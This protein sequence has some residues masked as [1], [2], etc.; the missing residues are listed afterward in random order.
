MESLYLDPTAFNYSHVD[1]FWYKQQPPIELHQLIAQYDTIIAWHEKDCYGKHNQH[2]PYQRAANAA[3]THVPPILSGC[4]PS[5]DDF[6]T[7]RMD[8]PKYPYIAQNGNG[9][10]LSCHLHELLVPA[11]WAAAQQH[12]K[13]LAECV[14]LK[15]IVTL[16]AKYITFLWRSTAASQGVLTAPGKSNKAYN[17]AYS[18]CIGNEVLSGTICSQSTD[19]STNKGL[20]HLSCAEPAVP[21]LASVDPK[22]QN[23]KVLKPKIPEA[24]NLASQIYKPA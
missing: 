8:M 7:L 9:E 18:T 19:T 4:L 3:A 21:E 22:Q 23:L 1:T 14:T 2:K 15:S 10:S 20:P 5:T 12:A 16:Y 17:R 11:N 24:L 6:A 13:K